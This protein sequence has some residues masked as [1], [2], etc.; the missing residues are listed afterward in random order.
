[1]K[2]LGAQLGFL[3]TITTDS[4]IVY[5]RDRSRRAGST[6]LLVLLWL[7]CALLMAANLA[8]LRNRNPTPYQAMEEAGLSTDSGRTLVV[9]LFQPGDC[10]RSLE[11]FDDLNRLHE[12][13]TM[14][15]QGVLLLERGYSELGA[16]LVQESRIAFPV[17]QVDPSQASGLLRATGHT[18]TPVVVL[19]DSVGTFKGAMQTEALE[20]DLGFLKQAMN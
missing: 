17:A 14:T 4:P 12:A 11:I 9:A 2:G 7:S 13:G 6:S 8:L 18:H 3:D 10:G 15:I 20:W 19:F 1:M 16:L 5:D